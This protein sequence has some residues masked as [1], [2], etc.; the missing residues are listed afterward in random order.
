MNKLYLYHSISGIKLIRKRIISSGMGD[1]IIF[2][3]KYK[4][5]SSFKT[6]L[7]GCCKVISYSTLL[8]ASAKKI[9]DEFNNAISGLSAKYNSTAWW[10]SR[11]SERNTFVTPLFLF[12]SYLAVLKETASNLN[13]NELHVI[14]DDYSLIGAAKRY[15]EGRIW[16]KNHS[17]FSC[18][19]DKMLTHSWFI[20]KALSYAAKVMYRFF[21]YRLTRLLFRKNGVLP[22]AS[23][24]IHTYMDKASFPGDAYKEKYFPTLK[25]WIIGTGAQYMIC[26]VVGNCGRSFLDALKIA[27]RSIPNLI[28]PW[29]YLPWWI[30]FVPILNSLR[31]VTYIYRNIYINDMDVSVIF[32]RCKCFEFPDEGELEYYT[33]CAVKR[34][35]VIPKVYITTYE[36]LVQDKLFILGARR[37]QP[38]VRIFGNYHASLVDNW[39]SLFPASNGEAR[40]APFPDKLLLY[41][42]RFISEFSDRGIPR[43]KVRVAPALRYLYLKDKIS[44]EAAQENIAVVLPIQEN[45]AR[46]IMGMIQ[47]ASSGENW[48]FIIKEHPS[49]NINFNREYSNKYL[50]F[51]DKRL[52]EIFKEVSVIIATSSTSA[53]EAALS[54]RKV[55]MVGN[56]NTVLFNP[57]Y[58]LGIDCPVVY[59][60][61]EMKMAIQSALSISSPDEGKGNYPAEDYFNFN[62]ENM[63]EFAA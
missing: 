19:L 24:V 18:L 53:V 44:H 28:L 27:R 21:I 39:L 5:Y 34:A 2:I 3:Q 38:G 51:T 8:D 23:Y 57:F 16:V 42:N 32:E 36:N 40:I 12:S 52:D 15:Y 61:D 4:R 54:G 45:E 46:M 10:S 50:N 26:P 58:G 41:S 17:P 62:I 13:E 48:K 25:E 14:C 7:E 9:K 35:G 11:I 37:F 30:A 59:K 20:V 33:P 31:R 55:I 63:K 60:A 6:A 47:K 22:N 56:E 43:D 29:D 1:A 49:A